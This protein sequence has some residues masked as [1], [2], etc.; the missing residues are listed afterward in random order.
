MRKV[1]LPVIITILFGASSCLDQDICTP[2]SVPMLN[3]E[4]LNI[5]QPE[6]IFTDTLY[7]SLIHI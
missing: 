7:L 1:V 3:I 2:S 5:E 4:L 6:E